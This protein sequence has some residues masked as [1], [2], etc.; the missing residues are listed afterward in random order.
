MRLTRLFTLASAVLA[1]LVCGMLGRLLWG[2]WEHYRAAGTGHHTLQLMQ[3]AMVA[4]E[5][6]SY[7]RGPVNAVLGDRLPADPARHA[8]LLRARADTDL[9]LAQLRRDLAADAG[10]ATALVPLYDALDA[11]RL[12]VDQLAALPPAERTPERLDAAIERMFQLVPLALNAVTSYTRASEQVYPR[13]ARIL[14]KARLTVELREF[15][16]RLGSALTV[17]LAT[18]R[19][20]TEADH[21]RLQFLRGR[22]EQLRQ[23]IKIP[24]SDIDS[25]PSVLAAVARMDEVYFAAGQQLVAEVEQASRA[26]RAYGMDTGQF[27]QRYVPSMAPIL[28]LRDVLLQEAQTQ[29]LHDY[30]VARRELVLALLVGAAILLALTL[31]L[32]IVRRRVVV[33]L[34]RATRAVVRLGN[35]DFSMPP[36]G[37]R[38]DDEIGDMLRALAT[39]RANSMDRQRLEQERVHLIEELRLRADTDYLTGILN[40]RAFTA[41]GNLRLRGAREQDESLAVI[42]FDVDHFK[43]VND[44]YGHDAG[45]QVL[46]RIA[47]V[48]RDT[49]RDGEIV[50]RY[51]GEEFVVMPT[52]CGLEAARALAERLRAAISHEPLT[53]AD[54]HILRV[55]AS[56]GVAVAH[57]PHAAL[58]D[59]FHAADLALYRAKRNGRNR[60]ESQV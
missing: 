42:L 37:A 26:G 5:K 13:I 12:T 23:L 58:D 17:P 54:G 4:A 31:L 43:S 29:A 8:R 39:L 25:E 33:P 47:E 56:F 38:R 50:A 1:L 60:V 32:A 19:P 41:A 45:D 27:A 30:E 9:A 52:Y 10:P 6:L 7:E 49:L 18:P 28:A 15:A 22:I 2:E 36:S 59:L 48:V 40:R 14:M 35:G 44:S 20:L 34:L 46:I 3:R 24:S 55:T 57:G 11:A 21:Q 51:G 53:L 16:G